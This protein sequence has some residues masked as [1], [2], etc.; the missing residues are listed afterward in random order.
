MLDTISD[1][2]DLPRFVTKKWIEFYDQS[3]GNYNVN[4]EI[5]IKNPMLRSDSCDFRDAYIVVKG[6]IAVTAP[7]NA[8][9]NRSVA[10]KNNAP[11]LTAFQRSIL[12]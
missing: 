10:S 7:D 5:R 4:K 6:T 2:K 9:G 12:Y 8:K 1:D 3:E 11:L